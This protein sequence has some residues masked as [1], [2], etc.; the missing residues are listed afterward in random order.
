MESATLKLKSRIHFSCA[1]IITLLMLFC[2]RDHAVV[3]AAGAPQPFLA[4]GHPVDWWFVFKFNSA[5]FPDCGAEIAR[6][7]IFGGSPKEYR[8]FGQ[9]FV[10]ASSENA[11][12]QKGGD[13][14]GDSTD[15]PIG[16]TFDQV[17][18]GSF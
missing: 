10:Y 15:D 18:N 3:Q 14:V 5:T 1:L 12:L 9:Q 17:Y 11:K 13:C 6:Q 2:G 16:A 4:K 7:C 8:F